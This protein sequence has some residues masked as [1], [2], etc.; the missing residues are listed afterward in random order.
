GTPQVAVPKPEEFDREWYCR[1]SKSYKTFCK[2]AELSEALRM[3]HEDWGVKW[4]N[5]SKEL[6]LKKSSFATKVLDE[7][8]QSCNNITAKLNHDDSAEPTYQIAF[9]N[10]AKAVELHAPTRG[11]ADKLR[12]MDTHRRRVGGGSSG[13]S[14]S[15]DGSFYIGRQKDPMWHDMSVVVEIKGSNEPKDSDTLR[16]QIIQGFIDM[17]ES[18]PRR[19][20][21]GIS[22]GNKGDIHVYV[23]FPDG[24]YYAHLGKL[25]LARSTE[26]FKPNERRV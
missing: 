15:P 4:N 12:W 7:Y 10:L 3:I 1:L 2:P 26:E 25:P 16:G 11:K 17:A 18:R 14:R 22:L 23:C 24:I 20:S 6:M 5:I 21:F 13:S 19:F 8:C 9:D